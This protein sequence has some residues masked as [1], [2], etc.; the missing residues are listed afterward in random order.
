M[1]TPNELALA[2]NRIIWENSAGYQSQ[3]SE[4]RFLSN[5]EIIFNTYP[6]YCAISDAELFTL[7][8]GDPEN[9]PDDTEAPEWIKNKYPVLH[10]L[11]EE[12]HNDEGTI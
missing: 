4:D 7:V 5:F 8:A 11:I 1:K 3:L 2:L 12:F 10:K 9:H 6:A